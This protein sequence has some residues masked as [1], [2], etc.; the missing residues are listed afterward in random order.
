M[1]SRIVSFALSAC[2]S[3]SSLLTIGC[4]NFRELGKDLKFIDETVVVSA[5]ITNA[6][7]F[8]N[9]RGFTLDWNEKQ[10]TVRSGDATEV[11]GLGV[12]GFFVAK[13]DTQYIC[14]YSDKNGDERYQ[15]GEPAWIS[16]GPDG[17]PAPLDLTSPEGRSAKGAL[18]SKTVIPAKLVTATYEFIDNTPPGEAKSGWSIPVALGEI[19]ELDEPRFSS[20]TGAEG[21]WQPAGYAMD[22]GIGIYFLEKY[23]PN[24]I[25][26]IFVYGAAGS[27]QDWTTF[28]KEFDRKRY[29]LWFYQ[30]P[31]AERLAKSG[32]ALNR[33]IQL[34]QSHY[35]F[36][37]LNIVAHSMGGLV[38]RDAVINNYDDGN[39]YIKHFVTISSPFGGMEFARSGVK[40]ASSVVPSWYDMV[41]D[42]DFQQ[43][44]FDTKLKGKIPYLLIYGT[45]AKRSMILPAENDGTVSVESVTRDDAIKDAIKVQGFDEDHVSI[46]SNPQVIQMVEDFL[47]S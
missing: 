45:K 8:T 14:A 5:R 12:F 38:S 21:Y 17:K 27:P 25:P 2:L 29:Q 15:P 16:S 32:G 30:Y 28:F 26:V 9:I 24:R 39:R 31:S 10:N 40:H 3:I 33:G 43:E 35:G 7:S 22:T 19:A 37:E 13:T 34:L 46:L 6:S 20:E 4:A 11:K 47:G 44:L 42:S 23:D 41:P 36:N 1:I 18:S